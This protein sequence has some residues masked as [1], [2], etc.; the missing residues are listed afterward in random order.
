MGYPRM[1]AAKRGELVPLLLTCLEG[2]PS[3]QQD[4]L[5]QLLMASLEH[6][7]IPPDP[8][9]RI[10]MFGLTDKPQT[11][12]A[13]LDYIMDILILPYGY[14]CNTLSIMY[15]FMGMCVQR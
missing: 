6:V 1:D 12:K 15:F 2:K 4:S 11:T 5:L 3:T 14:V 9:Q 8:K 10:A 13:L 7:K